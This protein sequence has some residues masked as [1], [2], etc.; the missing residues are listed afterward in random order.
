M[1]YVTVFKEQEVTNGSNGRTWEIIYQSGPIKQFDNICASH[2]HT[3]TCIH[4]YYI[5]L[6][7]NNFVKEIIISLRVILY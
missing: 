3:E 5:K 2:M 7:R 4:L 1:Q 6:Y